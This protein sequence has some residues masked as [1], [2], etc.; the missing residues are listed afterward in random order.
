MSP[1]TLFHRHGGKIVKVH[2]IAHCQCKPDQGRSRDYWY[3]ECDVLWD[4]SGTEDT[5]E[6]EPF[7][8]GCD[9]PPGN[10]ELKALM[11][12]MNAYLLE[13]GAWYDTGPHEGWYAH[14]SD[15]TR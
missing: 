11:E 12:A 8:L 6:V 14:R 1:K 5:H 7:K 15:T 10:A 13:H 3:F 2:G 9:D 4:D